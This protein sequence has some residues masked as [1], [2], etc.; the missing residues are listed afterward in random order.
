MGRLISLGLFG[1]TQQAP[2]GALDMLTVIR[3]Q[4]RLL[5]AF[6]RI[7]ESFAAGKLPTSL[8]LK[9]SSLTLQPAQ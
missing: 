2:S 3:E 1:T 4:D 5:P 7:L 8:V 6:H 9:E